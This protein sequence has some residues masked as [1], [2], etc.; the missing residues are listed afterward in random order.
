MSTVRFTEEFKLEAV[1]QVTEHQHRWPMWLSG[2][3]SRPTACMHG[4]SGTASRRRRVSEILARPLSFG[5][6]EL[7]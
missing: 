2:L 3:A 6:C 7:R 4:S 1:K 5:A